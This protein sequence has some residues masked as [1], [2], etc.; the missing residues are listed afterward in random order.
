M[1]IEQRSGQVKVP[2]YHVRQILTTNRDKQVLSP[3][4][5]YWYVTAM[6][7]VRR[8]VSKFVSVDSR[9]SIFIA[10]SFVTVIIVLFLDRGRKS[11]FHTKLEK[12]L[13]RADLGDLVGHKHTL[14]SRKGNSIGRTSDF[15][16]R[17]AKKGKRRVALWIVREEGDKVAALFRRNNRHMFQV[18]EKDLN[19]METAYKACEKMLVDMHL[20]IEKVE[21]LKAVKTSDALKKI[22]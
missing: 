5:D 11:F 16:T 3:M 8:K 20:D 4:A 9:R 12:T 2:T 22:S 1:M 15:A 7:F 6:S 13:D 10:I 17:S 14:R 21:F 18:F 19:F